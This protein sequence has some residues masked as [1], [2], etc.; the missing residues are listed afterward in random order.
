MMRVMRTP[1]SISFE[2]QQW[3]LYIHISDKPVLGLLARSLP[4]RI[5]FDMDLFTR[6]V[7]GFVAFILAL[8]CCQ[9]WERSCHSLDPTSTIGR[10]ATN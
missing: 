9:K 8:R 5:M 3:K 6:S 10:M 7:N 2:L 1:P 4:N